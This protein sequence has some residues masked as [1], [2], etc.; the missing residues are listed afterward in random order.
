LTAAIQAATDANVRRAAYHIIE[1]KG[2]T[3]FG[4]G[5]ALSR[6]SRCI[7][8]DER[9]VFTASSV[10]SEIE[11]VDDVALSLPLVLGRTGIE[12][13]LRPS[14]SDGERNALHESAA[15]IKQGITS[16]GF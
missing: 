15:I 1:G 2:S 10:V 8:F 12:T 7:L 13:T 14:M 9:M 3:Y 5:A 4:I 11:G 16:L 6:M